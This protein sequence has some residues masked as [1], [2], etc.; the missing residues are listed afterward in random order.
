M[1][2]KAIT[3]DPRYAGRLLEIKAPEDIPDRWKGTPHPELCAIAELRGTDY[4][5]RHAGIAYYNLH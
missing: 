4:R 3:D 2:P 5:Y 1:L